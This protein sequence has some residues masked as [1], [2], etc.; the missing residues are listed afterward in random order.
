MAENRNNE[1][2]I[3]SGDDRRKYGK[4]MEVRKKKELV[5]FEI[6]WVQCL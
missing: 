2:S 4:Q 6:G 5:S 1:G 3:R